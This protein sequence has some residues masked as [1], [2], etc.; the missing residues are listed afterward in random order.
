MHVRRVL[1]GLAL[2]C[3]VVVAAAGCATPTNESPAENT[4]DRDH[5]GVRDDMVTNNST[6]DDGNETLPIVTPTGP[7]YGP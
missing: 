3:F 7:G 4:E 5:D 1:T 2:V 6:V